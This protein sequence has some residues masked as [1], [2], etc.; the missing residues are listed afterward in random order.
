MP[1]LWGMMHATENP[2]L[3]AMCVSGL[4]GMAIGIGF[5]IF[6]VDFCGRYVCLSTKVGVGS[7]GVSWHEATVS[8]KKKSANSIVLE[9][10]LG[11]ILVYC[12]LTE[13]PLNSFSVP[14]E[15]SILFMPANESGVSERIF[16]P[17]Q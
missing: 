8:R 11:R 2:G 7:R 6:L 5:Y 17:S 16:D 12:G 1:T 10:Y 4:L 14:F 13:R 3:F 15:F 9:F